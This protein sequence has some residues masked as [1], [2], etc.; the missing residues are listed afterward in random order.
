MITK[1][2]DKIQFIFCHWDNGATGVINA[3]KAVNQ[4]WANDVLI[5]GV[6]GNKTGFAAGQSWTNYISI[7]QNAETITSKV[8]EQSM[9]WIKKDPAAVKENI[10][11]F[12]IITRTRSR[13]S[14]LPSGKALTQATRPH[15]GPRDEVSLILRTSHTGLRTLLGTSGSWRQRR[16][17]GRGECPEALL[18]INDVSKAFPGV[19]A[20]DTVSL[21]VRPASSTASSARTGRAS[22]RS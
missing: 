9:L 18:T 12:D 21:E 2:G 3:L 22:P 8:M 5:I 7:A 16:R 10:I 1:Y 17:D 4:P 14:P 13:T 11:P 6:D 20:L 15:P 19:K